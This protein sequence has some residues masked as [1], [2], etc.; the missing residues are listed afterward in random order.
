MG[1]Y[2]FHQRFPEAVAIGYE[3]ALNFNQLQFISS[4]GLIWALYLA[5]LASSLCFAMGV[6]PKISGTL[7]LILHALFVGRNP[8]SAW[9]WSIMIR[10][11][12]LY[13]ILGSQSLCE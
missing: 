10:P 12:L 1:G 7:C 2:E 4:S 5:L 8:A 3:A 6:R 11:F 13:A 9:G